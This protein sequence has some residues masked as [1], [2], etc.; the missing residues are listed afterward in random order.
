MNFPLSSHLITIN[1]KK[2][3]INIP[4]IFSSQ[5]KS[6]DISP[7]FVTKL[8]GGWSFEVG[9]GSHP[10]LDGCR[11][12]GCLVPDNDEKSW[13]ILCI[14]DWNMMEKPTTL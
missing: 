5:K 13:E 9:L 8:P 11:L 2:K 12:R 7:P 14:S 10:D 4:R 3:S 6:H 1:P